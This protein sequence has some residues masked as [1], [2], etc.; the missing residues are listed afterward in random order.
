MSFLNKLTVAFAKAYLGSPLTSRCSNPPVINEHKRPLNT[1]Y[2]FCF[3]STP[4]RGVNEAVP[5]LS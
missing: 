2:E 3:I 1:T 5:L 4:D